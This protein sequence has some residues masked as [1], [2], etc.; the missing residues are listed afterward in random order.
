M[1]TRNQMKAKVLAASV[2]AALSQMAGTAFADSSVGQD[3]V[4][5]SALNRRPINTS[6]AGGSTDPEGMGTREPAARTPS[7]QMYDMPIAETEEINKT[8]GGWEYF[9]HVEAGVVGIDGDRKRQ[10]F[11]RYKDVENGLYLNNFGVT[12]NKRDSANFF[13]ATGGAVGNDDEFYSLKF[14]RYNDWMV[15]GFYNETPHVFTTT[16]RSI[17]NG[18]GSGNLTLK[19]GLTPG[20]TASVAADNLAVAAVANANSNTEL[21]LVRK[22]GG[23]RFDMNLTNEWKFFASYTNEKREGKRPFGS[24]W[25][26]GGGSNPVE[27]V[28][29]ID[30]RSHDFIA[31]LQYN[32]DLNSL[33]LQ[34]S[35][36][37][38]RNDI[39]T[40]TFQDPYRQA[41]AN[42]IAAGGFTQGRFDLYPDN[43][44]YNAKGEYAR[45]LPDFYKGRFTAVAAFASS[46]QDDKL[47]PYTT[48]P[49][50][51]LT[52]VAGAAEN[53]DNTR[54]LSK[55]S[56]GAQIDTS[57]LDLGLSLNPTDDLNLKGKLRY[58]ETKNKTDYLACNPS[59]SYTDNDPYTAGAQAGG[60]SAYGCTGVW[61]RLTNDGSGSAVVTGATAAATALLLANGAAGNQNIRNIPFDYKKLN[62]VIGGDYRLN[63]YSSVNAAYERE[64]IERDHRERDKTWEDKLKLGYVNRG[65]EDATLRLSYEH[66]DRRGDTYH[67]H[68]PYEEFYSGHLIPMPTAVV[69]ATTTPTLTSWV[70]HMNSRTR[71]YDLADRK[72]DTLNARLNYMVRADLDM[73]VTGQYKN[74]TYPDSDYGRVE[75]QR[76]SSLNF[77]A[78]YQPSAERSF[79]GFYTYSD[80]KME[81]QGTP[82][83]AAAG[84]NCNLFAAG[85]PA[86]VSAAELLCADPNSGMVFQAANF[87]TVTHRDQNDTL[88]L[89]WKE[90]F[91]EIRLDMNYSFSQGKTDI[92]Y[93]LPANLAA[94]NRLLAGKGMPELK[95]T[96]HIFEAN[97]LVPV[98]KT[99]STRFMV[100][101]EVGKI[102]DWHYLGF[103]TTPVSGNPAALPTAVILDAGPQDYTTSII[104]VMVNFKL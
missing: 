32:D 69:G 31:G 34:L 30:Y 83:G 20:G 80:A 8:D 22:K 53:W 44:Y 74:T 15:K 94:A 25:G 71:K 19:P 33:N 87:W 36:S 24:V 55:R 78:N 47:I 51:D 11:N 57:L 58:Y 70:V 93:N 39:D 104:G 64:N 86:T 65:L 41:A 29:P 62:F 68:S 81:Q 50:V 85:G 90:A 38:F 45:S 18:L 28:E 88:G 17:Y 63:K 91:G 73:G 82:S 43:D 37:W 72:N 67:V 5:S 98:N 100:R 1:D 84:R 9:G 89:G 97:V 101:H 79:Y 21:G 12:M 95:T 16:F 48:I 35:G 2:A 23:A 10:G 14:G 103:D 96:Q 26:G 4:M 99:V 40:L 13:E 7:G 60:L 61:G 75:K 52:N 46:R 102:N 54:S 49:G 6:T 76:A 42:G 3:T 59:A 92:N 77:D 56:A 27:T 66:Q